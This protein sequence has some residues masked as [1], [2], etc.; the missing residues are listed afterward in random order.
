[1]VFW[2]LHEAYFLEVG[3]TQIPVGHETLSIIVV[4]ILERMK[5]METLK[6]GLKV[7]F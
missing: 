5:P 3:L 4:Q 1:M 7:D 6:E 2:K